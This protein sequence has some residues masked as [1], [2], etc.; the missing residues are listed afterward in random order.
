VGVGGLWVWGARGVGGSGARAAA[1]GNPIAAG[2]L[3]PVVFSNMRYHMRGTPLPLPLP[4]AGAVV[5][6]CYCYCYL[7]CAWCS[8]SRLPGPG[9]RRKYAGLA[10]LGPGPGSG[11]AWE[12]GH[13]ARTMGLDPGP[14]LRPGHRRKRPPRQ[15]PPWLCMWPASVLFL[16]LNLSPPTLLRPWKRGWRLEAGLQLP[17]HIPCLQAVLNR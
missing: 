13:T 6:A 8:A 2:A 16:F 7:A 14:G 1:G 15:L 9:A 5:G 4:G 17:P 3:S 12:M 10:G 11:A